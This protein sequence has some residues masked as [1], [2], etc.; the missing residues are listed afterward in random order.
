MLTC[1]RLRR[2]DGSCSSETSAGATRGVLRRM[3]KVTSDDCSQPST[4]QQTFPP[5]EEPQGVLGAGLPLIQRLKLLKDKEEREERERANNNENCPKSMSMSVANEPQNKLKIEVI[6][7]EPEVVG[8]GLPLFARLR[9]LKVKEEK[10]RLEKE[11]MQ[12]STIRIP[13]IITDDTTK[14]DK[15]NKLSG[16][17]N[18]FKITSS[19]TSLKRPGGHLKGMLRKAVLEKNSNGDQ[20]IV[21]N[22][23]INDEIND[24]NKG[25]CFN[26]NPDGNSNTI[27]NNDIY[28]KANE[29]NTA[30]PPDDSI[31]DKNESD[32]SD[33]SSNKSSTSHEKTDESEGSLKEG[34]QRSDSF[35]KAMGESILTSK[36]KNM[37]MKGRGSNEDIKGRDSNEDIKGSSSSSSLSSSSGQANVDSGAEKVKLS[38][39]QKETEEKKTQNQQVSISKETAADDGSPEDNTSNREP[40]PGFLKVIT[41]RAQC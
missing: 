18:N 40:E 28:N 41:A 7:D 37:D 16:K 12:S 26:D 32:K 27:I 4:S 10:E 25:I 21:P 3:A 24:L 20:I 29:V 8:A 31:T 22:I 35:R 14:D 5:L 6:G 15:I 36:R 17:C 19:A 34:V 13:E 1:R 38:S 2:D 30:S 33:G 23:S 11:K 39:T 9:L